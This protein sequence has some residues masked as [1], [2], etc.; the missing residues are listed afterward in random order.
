[1]ILEFLPPK[2]LKSIISTCKVLSGLATE[3][4]YTHNAKY[5]NSTAILWAASASGSKKHKRIAFQ[6]LSQAITY[7]GNVNAIHRCHSSYVTALHVATDQGDADFV[8]QLIRHGA[9]TSAR[10]F[11]F[12]DFIRSSTAIFDGLQNSHKPSLEPQQKVPSLEWLPLIFPAVAG[13]W[14]LARLLMKNYA[15][16]YIAVKQNSFDSTFGMTIIHFCILTGTFFE[17]S[18][19]IINKYRSCI[20]IRSPARETTALMMSIQYGDEKIGTELLMA[21]ANPNIPDRYGATPLTKALQG[22]L[23]FAWDQ[24]KR[25]WCGR[26]VTTLL[27]HGADPNPVEGPNPLVLAIAFA[28]D[29]WVF[30]GRSMT[31]AIDALLQRDAQVNV[32]LDNGL[33]LV[34]FLCD[35]IMEKN[36]SKSLETLLEKFILKGADIQEPYMNGKTILAKTMEQETGVKTVTDLL[37]KHGAVLRPD[38]ADIALESW[39]LHRS[40]WTSSFDIATC[41]SYVTQE[42]INWAFNRVLCDDIRDQLTKFNWI[43]DHFI[44]TSVSSD[45]VAKAFLKVGPKMILG[46][47]TALPFDVNWVDGEG[48][49]F[50]HLIVVNLASCAKYKEKGALW[51]TNN[52]ITAGISVLQRDNDGRTALG[53]LMNLPTKYNEL[54]NLLHRQRLAEM[55]EDP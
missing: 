36:G 17:K 33:T 16:G 15:P 18:E 49:G 41:Q 51:D 11:L 50:L 24:V 52:L 42:K 47:L 1:M 32:R 55:G 2:S 22:T 43:Q 19:K 44:P 10:C 23:A 46:A 21:N 6:V 31:I 9:N 29:D 40:A 28:K 3:V 14:P 54:E 26:F 37:L 48:R 25:A 38:D 39:I 13:N 53:R 7:K 20:D 8:G 12:Y 30:Q 35:I 27:D 34:Q 45:A 5:D 4:L